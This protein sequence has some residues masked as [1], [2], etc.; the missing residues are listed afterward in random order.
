MEEPCSICFDAMDMRPFEDERDNTETCVKLDCGHAYHT[1]CIV[2]CLSQMNRKCPNC[3]IDKTPMQELTREG[4]AKKLLG[5]VKRDSEVKFL[6]SEF[7]ESSSEYADTISTLKKDIK[8]FII[9]RKEE[10]RVDE[11]RRYMLECLAKV[12]STSKTVSRTKGPQ[13][14]AA[15]RVSTTRTYW[16]GTGFERMFFGAQEAYRIRRLKVPRLIIPLY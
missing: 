6:I 10:L 11:K 15:L 13:Y 16:R 4:L 12:Q 8:E 14:V 7:K 9:K 3:N 1:R 2:R 5:E